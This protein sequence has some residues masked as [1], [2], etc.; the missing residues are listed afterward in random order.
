MFVYNSYQL[1]LH[2]KAGTNTNYHPVFEGMDSFYGESRIYLEDLFLEKTIDLRT[3]NVYDF[4][5]STTDDE[6]RFVLH[7][8]GV[9]S[10]DE[11]PDLNA[12]KIFSSQN[13]VYIQSEQLP[14]NSYRVEVFN[15]LGQIVFSK[16][17]EPT[18][19]SSF[20]LNEKTGIYIVRLHS[21]NR[22]II[23]KV[24]IHSNNN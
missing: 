10:T 19:R 11:I 1:P 8:Y 14:K 20:I 16:N 12:T 2:F 22:S 6:N 4:T 15:L 7:F 18:M 24:M 5:A 13:M 17:I 3:Q 23:Q 9:T 21:E